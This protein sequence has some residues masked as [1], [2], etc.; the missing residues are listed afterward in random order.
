[1]LHNNKLRIMRLFF[2]NPSESFQLR[3]ISRL[4]KIAV[5]S[6]TAYA[7]SLV[8]EDLII[9]IKKGIYPSY[10]ANRDNEKFR[11]Y[12]KLDLIERIESSGLLSY[13]YDSCMPDCIILFGSASLGEDIEGSDIDMFIQSKE[14]KLNLEKYEKILSRKIS[15]F[16]EDNFSRLSSELKNNILNGIKLKGYIKVF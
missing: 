3:Q 6:V 16:F 1:M 5:T 9:L 7:N 14:K 11:L 10:K 8:K 2:D 15:L 4:A 12:K 13:L